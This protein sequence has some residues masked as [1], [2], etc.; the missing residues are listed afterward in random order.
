MGVGEASV[1]R[2]KLRDGTQLGGHISQ[3]ENNSFSITDKGSSKATAVAYADV[4]GIKG[5]GMSSR[6][7]VLIGVGVGLGALAVL[8][9]YLGFNHA[10]HVAI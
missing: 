6:T 4:R 5:K 1:V 9:I 10:P 8:A 7:E 3:I 2:V